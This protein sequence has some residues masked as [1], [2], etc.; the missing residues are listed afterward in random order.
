[1]VTANRYQNTA[2]AKKTFLRIR[3]CADAGLQAL[4]HGRPAGPEA[5]Q[6]AADVQELQRFV[7]MIGVMDEVMVMLRASAAA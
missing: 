1:M 5:R 6:I 2:A 4:A 7:A 3:N